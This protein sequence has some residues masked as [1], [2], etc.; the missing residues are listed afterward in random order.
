[1]QITLSFDAYQRV[2]ESDKT[3]WCNNHFLNSRSLSQA[4]NVREQLCSL[5]ERLHIPV[6]S[7]RYCSA[8][9]QKQNVK[10]CLCHGFFM[11]SAVFDRDGNYRT[12]KDNQVGSAERP[13]RRRR[14]STR[15]PPS[16]GRRSG[17]STTNSFRPR[18]TI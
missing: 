10:R 15:R 8:L 11:Q 1:M 7:S 17:S 16:R 14:E 9:E 4:Y 12:A 13:L 2:S 5:V 18:A 3:L 6:P